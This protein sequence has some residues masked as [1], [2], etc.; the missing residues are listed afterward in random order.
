MVLCSGLAQF[1]F[2]VCC[3]SPA[4]LF[5]TAAGGHLTCKKTLDLQKNKNDIDKNNYVKGERVSPY[6][7]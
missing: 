1:T 6:R 3:L 2:N 7:L 4:P 5:S